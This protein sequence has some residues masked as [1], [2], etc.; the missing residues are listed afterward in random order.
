MTV[1]ASGNKN[2]YN[3]DGVTTHWSYTFPIINDTDIHVYLTDLSGTVSEVTSNFTVDSNNTRVVYPSVVSGLPPLPSGWKIT[4]IRQEPQTQG[5]DLRNQGS[6]NAEVLEQAFDKATLIIQDQQ[7]TLSRCVKYPVDQSPSDSTTAT[8]L[9][10]IEADKAAAG[11]SATAAAASATSASASQ[12]AAAGSATAAAASASSAS[13][14]A[15]SA[16]TSATS[17]TSSA[18]SASTSASNAATS[19]TGAAASKTAADTD[20]TNAAASA[21]SASTSASSASTSATAAASS[22]SAASSSAT[23]AAS[24]ASSAATSATAA[25]TAAS[26]VMFRDVVFKTFADSPITLDSTYRGKM[27]AIDASGGAVVVNLPAIAG[28]DLSSAFVVGVKKTDS[29]GNSITVNRGSTDTI[30]GATSK[31]IGVAGAGTTLIP[32]IDPAPDQWTSADFG[33][34]AGNLTRDTFSGNGSTVAFTLSV[35]PGAIQNTFVYINGV[36]QRKTTYSLSGTTLTFTEAPPTGTSNVEV[37]SGTTLSIGTPADGTVTNAKMA[38]MAANSLKGNNTGSSAVPLDLTVAQTKAM[39]NSVPTLQKFTATGT[40]TGWLFTISTS[41]TCAAGDTYTNN[42]NTYTV[43]AALSAQTGQ[44]LFCSGASAPTG[45]GTLTRATGSGTA[46]VTFTAATALA[47]YTTPANAL[48]LKVRLV[49]GGGGGGGSGTGASAG[50]GGAGAATT[51]G[52]S[53]LL[54]NG[55]SG[56]VVANG[57]GGGGAGGSASLGTAIGVAFSGGSGGGSQYESGATNNAAGGVGAASPFG[58]SG[59]TA[60]NAAAGSN[61]AANTGSGGGGGGTGAVIGNSSGPGGGAG[62]FVDAI[63][64][65]PAGS[66]VYCVGSGGSAGTLGTSGAAGGTGAAGLIEVIEYYQ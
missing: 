16:S 2:V 52:A 57:G 14:S 43:L 8:F 19:A 61:A 38:N 15:S 50:N 33:A 27:L 21:S 25:Q 49:G 26:S 17:A 44:V 66:Y 6:L 48:Y 10:T 18:S 65:A 7:E 40:T 3:G 30:D 64:T 32:D 31:T 34:T 20:A 24:S 45:S 1:A 55:G 28:L 62:G 41:T 23:A 37:I 35:S 9:S 47:T 13:T 46:S 29:S 58:G 53:L 12:T 59:G 36:Y 22:A 5:V 11:A 4:L 42:G 39:L 54:G 60:A 56:G 63:I 51:F